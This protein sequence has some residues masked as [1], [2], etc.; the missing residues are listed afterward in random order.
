MAKLGSAAGI[1]GILLIGAGVYFVADAAEPIYEGMRLETEG[2]PVDARIESRHFEPRV[3]SSRPQLQSISVNG[4][5]ARSI[6]TYF[7]RHW[8]T[9]RYDA[10][11]EARTATAPVSFDT[12]RDSQTGQTIT[13]RALEDGG[14]FVDAAPF[15]TFFHGLKAVGIGILM[16]IIGF[17][18]M[19]LP[20]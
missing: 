13:V 8:L 10:G 15:A 9:V 12:W 3:G 1:F 20:D 16:A 5:E 7:R 18:S 17:V 6:R 19:R 2:Q 11:G 14:A 4:V